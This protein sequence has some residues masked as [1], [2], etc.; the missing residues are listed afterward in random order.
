MVATHSRPSVIRGVTIF[1]A[2]FV[3]NHFRVS[4]SALSLI[5][6]L[7]ICHVNS[8]A[9]D[10][11]E[12]VAPPNV[13]TWSGFLT[14]IP[15]NQVDPTGLPLNWTP[16]SVSWKATLPGEG[17]SS[18][19]VWGDSA[20]VT[21]VE[22]PNKETYHVSRIDLT[23]GKVDW[24]KSVQSTDPVESTYLVS[25]AAPTP[26]CDAASVYVFFES[27]DLVALTHQGEEVWKRSLSQDYGRFDNKFGLAASPVQDEH[28]LYILID[29]AGP[30]Y[31]LAINKKDGSTRWKTPRESRRSWSSPFLATIDGQAQIVCSSVG[32]V[33][34][35][36]A[37]A[38][39]QLWS[40]TDVGAN[41]SATPIVFHGNQ[42]LLG[43]AVRPSEGTSEKAE[44]TNLLGRIVRNDD[45]WKFVVEWVAEKARGSFS[46]PVSLQNRAYWINSSGVIYC[47]DLKSGKELFSKRL[48]CG[49]CW[50]TPIPVGDR[51]YAFGKDGITTVLQASDEYIELAASNR[52]WAAPEEAEK[53]ADAP[54]IQGEQDPSRRRAMQNAA[55][56]IQY[57]AVIIPNQILIRSGNTLHCLKTSESLSQ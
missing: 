13:P 25:R 31:L 39:K 49:P 50:A 1:S 17:Q 14:G 32:S 20:F 18:P 47:L 30:S 37:D 12:Q 43:A 48:P 23:D 36:D 7:E 26:V 51:I 56:P 4:I 46:S 57:G 16:E 19:V 34:G 44:R 24:T 55:G 3:R 40:H 28:S 10:R 45:G 21:T 6:C 2:R 53:K 15:G 9:D 54:S 33:D 52:L 22:G 8:L 11:S 41:S 5:A 27:G 29:H 38:G 42:V 35:Y